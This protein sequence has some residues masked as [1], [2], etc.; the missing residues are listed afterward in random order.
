MSDIN[1]SLGE[2]NAWVNKVEK[3]IEEVNILLDRVYECVTDYEE[4]DDTIYREIEKAG[5]SF[6]SAWKN[7]GK[8]Y[9]D[10]FE[11]LRFVFKSQ[12]KAVEDA[13]QAIQREK[14]KAKS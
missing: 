12:I 1:I 8:A 7:L 10:V 6:R 14:Q 9:K 2:A 4:K 3:E 13:K 11:G 5:G